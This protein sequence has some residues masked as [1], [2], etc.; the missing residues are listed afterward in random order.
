MLRCFVWAQTHRRSAQYDTEHH[1]G[2]EGGD[3]TR[4][5]MPCQGSDG[6]WATGHRGGRRL[7]SD[8]W[9]AQLWHRFA[10][11]PL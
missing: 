2:H 10:A 4:A 11:R 3:V 8:V 5:G 1:A 9:G 6:C 7:M